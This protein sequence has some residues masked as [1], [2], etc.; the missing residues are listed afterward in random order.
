M[1]TFRVLSA[2]LQ[3][4]EPRILDHLDEMVAILREEDILP[5]AERVAV[6]AF[7]CHLRALPTFSAESAYIETFERGKSSS[8]HLFEH[9]HGES[10]DRGQAMVDLIER[11]RQ[12]GL[13]ISENELPDYLPLFLEFLSTRPFAEARGYLGEVIDIVALIAAR[14]RKRETGY[15]AVVD[16]IVCLASQPQAAVQAEAAAAKEDPD[17]T[18]E[19]LDAAWEEAPVTFDQA[20]AGL[21]SNDG[22]P[23]AA[24]VV[25]RFAPDTAR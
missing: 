4:P 23:A 11:Y 5:A 7:I 16:A 17:F 9:I 24:S 15:A 25:E 2:L 18:P 21:D 10:R 12:H 8:L 19:A 22:C 3:Y 20:G 6:E 14:L 13:E 1:L